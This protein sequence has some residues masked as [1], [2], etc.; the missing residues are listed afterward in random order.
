MNKIKYIS[1]CDGDFTTISAEISG[2][3]L[4]SFFNIISNVK[5]EVQ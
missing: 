2:Y 3:L 1:S 5:G 4:T